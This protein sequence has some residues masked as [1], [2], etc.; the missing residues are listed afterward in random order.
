MPLLLT[1]PLAVVLFVIFLFVPLMPIANAVIASAI[2]ILI[3]LKTGVLKPDQM[4]WIKSK[5][6]S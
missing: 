2:Y 3:V 6:F 4:A 5:I 1:Y